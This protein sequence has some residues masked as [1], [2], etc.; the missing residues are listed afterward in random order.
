MTEELYILLY[1]NVWTVVF[2]RNADIEFRR[3]KNPKSGHISPFFIMLAEKLIFFKEMTKMRNSR[4]TLSLVLA[5]LMLVALLG[6]CGEKVETSPDISQ[7]PVDSGEPIIG[8]NLTV[9]IAQD[10]DETL[11]PHT[12]V[13]A[14]TREV[15]FNVYE[16]LV[17]PD[18]DGNLEP[19]VAKDFG[20]SDDGTVF[21]FTL[22]EN[23][24]FHNGETVTADDVVYS[25][26][27]AAGIG[28]DKPLV[29]GFEAVKSVESPDDSTVVVTL[30]EPN[31]EFLA[32]FAVAI[33]PDGSDPADEIVGTGPF[34]YVERVPQE[35]VVLEKFEDYWG[36]PAYVDK[37]TFKIIDSAETLVM[38]LK[39]GVLDLVAHLTSA[40]TNE[41]G[42]EYTIVEGTMNL[43][44]ALYL[45]NKVE[46]FD[47]VKVRQA[48]CYA[49]DRQSVMDLT[50][51]GRGAPVGSS[52]YPSF[53]KYF[54][55]DLVDYYTYDIEK[56]KELLAEAGYPDGFEF[57]VT[58]PSNYQPHVDTAAVLAEQLKKIGVTMNVKLVDWNTWVNDTYIGRN[59]EGTIIGVDASLMTARS[60]LERFTS[61][62]GSNF[63]NFSNDEYDEVF[64]Q[65]VASV[66]ADEQVERY[67]RLQEILTEQ[68]ANVY[69]Q[70]LC[71]MVAM[72]NGLRGY[73]FYPLYVMDLSKVYFTK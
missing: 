54:R 2:K 8:G 71:D 62:N 22:R 49:L 27:R 24:K 18:T 40:Q 25:L 20:I 48:L 5:T 57:D 39:S 31:V 65:A 63:I 7:Q 69:I 10:L 34:K 38:S 3:N 73:E 26:K 42:D 47:N 6:A 17:K 55:E 33:I 56:A 67:G 60:M 16:G 61:D 4:R 45:N 12:M 35:S 15:L 58:V 66:D 64:K 72:G 52:M 30:S 19:A 51:D 50:A 32:Q 46:P 70:D 41:L 37:V 53:T 29:E 14:G 23:V 28:S 1:M 44:Q 11:D 43:V 9:G 36:T 13:Y 59:F 68:A 21:T